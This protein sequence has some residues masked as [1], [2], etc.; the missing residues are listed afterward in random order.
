MLFFRL[1][2]PLSL[3]PFVISVRK[4]ALIVQPEPRQPAPM[5]GLINS[6]PARMP[7]SSRE[8]LPAPQRGCSHR[9]TLGVTSQHPKPGPSSRLEPFPLVSRRARNDF[10]FSQGLDGRQINE[11]GPGTEASLPKMSAA[12]SA[13]PT[14]G[15]RRDNQRQQKTQSCTVSSQQRLQL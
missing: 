3:P 10:L 5:T 12:H 2:T 15:C 7:R 6:R 14:A 13:V 1:H 9:P 8:G 4:Q 11:H